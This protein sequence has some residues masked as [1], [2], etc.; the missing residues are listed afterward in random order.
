[1]ST[2]ISAK[3]GQR[4]AAT[5]THLKKKKKKRIWLIA[6]VLIALAAG[7]IFIAGRSAA[8]DV[9]LI[10]YE[11]I[12]SITAGNISNA[13]NATGIV[14]SNNSHSIYSTQSYTVQE[15]LVE[16]GDKVSADTLLCRLDSSLLQEQLE[17][18]E[19][20]SALSSAASAQSVKT[21]QDSYNAAQS[22]V[23]SGTNASLV[24]AENAVRSA[25]ENWEKSKTAYDN[26]ASS[27][28]DGLNS[29]LI[30]QDGAVE[31]AALN[32]DSA[33]AA[34]D[35][36]EDTYYDAED[37]LDDF[38]PDTSAYDSAI[39]QAKSQR[40]SMKEL[41][42]MAEDERSEKMAVRDEAQRLHDEQ[43]TAE[44]E[45][46]LNEAEFNFALADGAYELA[47]SAYDSADS[48]YKQAKEQL[49]AYID[50]A[51][52][53]L[54]AQFEAAE[55]ALENA[56]R[57]LEAAQV[58]YE[59]ALKSREA[60]YSSADTTLAD[61]AAN[62]ENAYAAYQAAQKSYNA[63]K[64]GVDSSLQSS[65]NALQSAKINSSN[66]LSELELEN[67]RKDIADTEILAGCEGTVTAVYAQVGHSGAGLLFMIEDTEDL[68]IETSVK[69]YDVGT[70]EIGMPVTI[71]SEGTG[72]DVY[73][74]EII[75][76]A[77]AAS[78]N[79]MGVTDS[80]GEV[81][82][83]VKVKVSSADTRLK[84]GMNTRLNLII[85]EE[86][87]VLTVPYD[88][89]YNNADGRSCI[90]VLQSGGDGAQILTELPVDTGMANDTDIVVRGENIES[91]MQVISTPSR[92]MDM[93]GKAVTLTTYSYAML[94]MAAGG[95]M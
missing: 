63:A 15:V 44:T 64:A 27:L 22:A 5:G 3:D 59:T 31:N 6:V 26:Y 66:E 88:A 70:V 53:A 77:P 40:E 80:S 95:M 82:F 67:L 91:G 93:L 23:N 33:E 69:E 75:S 19:T 37:A 79:S 76:V 20:S 47:K 41:M 12:G 34:Y 49:E 61:Y 83:A 50:S 28:K 21:A 87:N 43:N 17:M 1:M 78:K 36:A 68:V 32:L 52:S 30:S 54:E 4:P 58:S 10:S 65:Y 7:G 13:I 71:K 85:E 81:Q 14:E 89:V 8:A 18:R 29:G 62:V 48:Q 9:A 92:Y 56:R 84:I 90:M 38:D 39:A 25:K 24:S 51:Y 2:A 57:G 74:G 94:N 11:D 46:A 42:L 55:S 60:A 16:V 72:S 86:A 73:K 45:A 35:K